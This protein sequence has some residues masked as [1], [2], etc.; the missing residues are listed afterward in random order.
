[1]NTHKSIW[2]AASLSL[3]AC[4]D[5]PVRNSTR[6]VSVAGAQLCAAH[7]KLTVHIVEAANPG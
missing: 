4:A 5:I 7:P 2:L 1:M 3:A 6:D